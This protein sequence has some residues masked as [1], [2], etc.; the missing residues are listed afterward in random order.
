MIKQTATYG[1][2]KVNRHDDNK[3]E[4]YKNGELCEKSTPALREIAAEIGLE[5]NPEWRTSQ[6]GANVLK[7]M[8]NAGEEK[9]QANATEAPKPEPEKESEPVP[10]PKDEA[11]NPAKRDF[12]NMS[13]EQIFKLCVDNDIEALEWLSTYFC[14]KTIFSVKFISSIKELDGIDQFIENF[15]KLGGGARI[16]NNR[17]ALQV[18]ANTIF[19][20]HGDV[21]GLEKIIEKQLLPYVRYELGSIPA[22]LNEKIEEFKKQN[23]EANIKR[24]Y[25]ILVPLCWHLVLNKKDANAAKILYRLYRYYHEELNKYNCHTFK[26]EEL[27]RHIGGGYSIFLADQAMQFSSRDSE[28][29]I[30][31]EKSLKEEDSERC[32]N[33]YFSGEYKRIKEEIFGE[34][35]LDVRGAVKKLKEERDDLKCEVEQLKKELAELKTKHEKLQDKEEALH[36]KYDE[37]RFSESPRSSSR[38]SSDDEVTVKVT[39][40]TKNLLLS[41]IKNSWKGTMTKAEYKSLLNGSMKARIAWVKANCEVGTFSDVLDATISLA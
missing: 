27:E 5:L 33:A 4:V 32:R 41:G 6:L 18:L 40:T 19:R 30:W 1:V 11:S 28:I 13:H 7:A 37:L 35:I 15:E 22:E 14:E 26:N 2:W 21:V 31:A 3:V 10:S 8:L 39:Y 17:N 16:P 34:N 36:Q 23:D 25:N 29:F 9:P 24:Y 12:E 20:V 38:S